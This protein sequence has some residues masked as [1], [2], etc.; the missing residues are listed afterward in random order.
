MTH[1]TKLIEY[2]MLEKCLKFSGN[3]IFCNPFEYNNAAT[4]NFH[5]NQ[6]LNKVYNK[7][8][9]LYVLTISP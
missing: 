3:A 5:V 1:S 2:I 4:Q 7:F 9:S 6:V 8:K